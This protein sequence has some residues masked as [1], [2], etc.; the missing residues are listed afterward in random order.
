MMKVDKRR[1]YIK[2]INNKEQESKT[3][4]N[5]SSNL[6]LYESQVSLSVFL[7]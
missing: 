1:D 5:S 3:K 4:R 2:K 7:F 6:F